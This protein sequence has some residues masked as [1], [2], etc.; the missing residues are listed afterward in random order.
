[1]FH[2]TKIVIQFQPLKLPWEISI[3]WSLQSN[4]LTIGCH[5]WGIPQKQN[6]LKIFPMSTLLSYCD[7]KAW[8]WAFPYKH[9]HLD[10]SLDNHA[11]NY[12]GGI[13][14]YPGVCLHTKS[15]PLL[16]VPAIWPSSGHL[17]QDCCMCKLCIYMYQSLE[18][19]LL[20]TIAMCE[21]QRKPCCFIPNLPPVVRRE[22]HSEN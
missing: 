2:Q 7:S 14:I 10:I 11:Y 13:W 1:M 18:R 4:L 8:L 3:Y 9:C 21:L 17:H 12:K 6:S 20:P 19:Q 5:L 22:R 16:Q 15:T